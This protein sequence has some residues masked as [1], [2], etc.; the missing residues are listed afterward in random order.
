[1]RWTALLPLTLSAA[2]VACSSSDPAD[3]CDADE[4]AVQLHCPD[5]LDLGCIPSEGVPLEL[6]VQ[7]TACDGEVALHCD[8]APGDIVSPGEATVICR[9]STPEG[10]LE[11]CEFPLRAVESGGFVLDCAADIRAECEGPLTTV[12]VPAPEVDRRCGDSVGAPVSDAPDE[13]FELGETEVTFSANG[14][15]GFSANCTVT[16]AVTDRLPPVFECPA[17]VELVASSPEQILR[18]PTLLARDQCQGELEARPSPEELGPGT[19]TVSYFAADDS[20]NSASC[21]VDVTVIDAWAPPALR[22][23]NASLREEGETSVTIAWEPS[24]GRGATGYRI[25]R[26][27][28]AEGPW[29]ELGTV[30]GERRFFTDDSL[31][32]EQVFYRVVTLADAHEGGST[33]PLRAFAIQG[34]TYDIRDQRVNTIRFDTTLY[35]VVRRPMNLDAG[36]FPLLLFLHGNHGNCR[37]QPF[38]RDD[39]CSETRDH[40]CHWPGF[41]TTPNAEGLAYL[42]ETLAAQGYVTAS[43][44]GNALNCRDDYIIERA[45][46]IIEHLRRWSSW[47]T[48]GGSPFDDELIGAIALDQVGLVGHSRGGEAVAH[49]PT[50]LAA[51]PIAGVNVASI[52]SIAPTDYHQPRPEGTPYA[53][54]LPGCDGD[55]HTLVGSNIYD[56]SLQPAEP[57]IRNQLFFPGAN[58]NFFS[59]EWRWDDN[60]WEQICPVE[61]EVGDIVQQRSLENVIGDW[62]KGT[63][64]SGG[65][66]PYLNADGAVPES[67]NAWSGYDLDLRI[68][69]SSAQRWLIDDFSGP[70]TPDI[71]GLGE[72]NSFAD[73]S[74]LRDCTADGC[75]S[76]FLHQLDA[77]LLSWNGSRPLATFELGGLDASE[78]EVLSFRLTSRWSRLNEGIERQDFLIRVVDNAGATAELPLSRLQRVPHLYQ[79]SVIREVLQTVRVPLTLLEELEPSLDV[80]DLAR[81]ELEMTAAGHGQGSILLSE[82]ELSR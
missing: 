52:F 24:E 13:G 64:G 18:P 21:F 56:R 23:A 45:E 71:N 14:E 30:D 16:V 22:I 74:A 57:V 7:A 79:T 37:P 38:D 17:E 32:A 43:L 26:A 65:L 28:A 80:G 58:H 4:P 20:G 68:S 9:A 42:G 75:G 51:T 78:A 29:S 1:M 35:G 33:E 49:V 41:V 3:E 36:P 31:P 12:A 34:E 70:A 10:D 53:V 25:E 55:V 60:R 76:A 44:S 77:L 6:D 27:L 82:L 61:A 46:L 72:M 73:Y 50:R 67:I 2:L 40:E 19:T 81:L 48:T 8:P 15:D 5:A 69:F 62:F 39:Q 11:T 66:A 54:L 47:A 59:T 63:L